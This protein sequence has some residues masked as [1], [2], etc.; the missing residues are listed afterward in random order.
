MTSGGFNNGGFGLLEI[1]LAIGLLAIF[2]SGTVFL[3]AENASAV[4]GANYKLQALAL[5]QE[6]IEAASSIRNRSWSNITNGPHG[7]GTSAGLWQFTGASDQQGPFTRT[8]TVAEVCST[9]NAFTESFCG[10]QSG[11][12]GGLPDPNAKRVT[13]KLQWSDAFGKANTIEMVNLLVNY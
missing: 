1:L 5:A 2:L 10:P 13:V 9:V 4:V 11:R 12:Y 3:T 7:L 6:G 8:I